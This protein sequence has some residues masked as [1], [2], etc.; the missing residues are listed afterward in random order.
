MMFALIATDMVFYFA[1]LVGAQEWML[2]DLFIPSPLT[3]RLWQ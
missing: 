3:L 1:H 2:A